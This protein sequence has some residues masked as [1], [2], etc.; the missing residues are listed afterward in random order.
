MSTSPQLKPDWPTKPCVV[1]EEPIPYYYEDG[2]L[3][4]KWQYSQRKTC[5]RKC[6]GYLHAQNRKIHEPL[7]E[8]TMMDKFIL[9]M[10]ND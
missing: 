3:I 9:G 4:K 8:P 10:I 5:G 7:P 6:Y 2:T 1:C